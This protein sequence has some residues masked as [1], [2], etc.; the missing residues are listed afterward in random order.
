MARRTTPRSSTASDQVVPIRVTKSKRR[1]AARNPQA[2]PEV[3]N[4]HLHN[5]TDEIEDDLKGVNDAF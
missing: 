5:H 4:A 2:F 1:D 3:R